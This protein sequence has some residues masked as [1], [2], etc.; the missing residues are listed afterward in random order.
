[1]PNYLGIDYGEKRIG[2]AYGDDLGVAT[3]IPAAVGKSNEIRFQFIE[4]VIQF[5][6]IQELIVGYPLNMNGT[7]GP[8]VEQVDRFIAKLEER[9]QLK[10][11]RVD[12]RL[13]SHQVEMEFKQMKQK[14]DRKSGEL[15]SRAATVFLQEFLDQNSPIPDIDWGEEY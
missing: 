1:M 5:R 15:D 13:S 7:K 8:R 11:H 4:E 6:N 12:E 10:V 3:P 9:F 14:L 2:L